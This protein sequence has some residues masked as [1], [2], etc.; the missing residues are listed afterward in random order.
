MGETNEKQMGDENE[1][2]K[3]AAAGDEDFSGNVI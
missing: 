3:P 2:G 1:Q